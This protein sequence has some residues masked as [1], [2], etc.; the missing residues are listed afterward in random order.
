MTLFVDPENPTKFVQKVSGAAPIFELVDQD[1]SVVE[2]PAEAPA[3]DEPGQ[4]LTG[5][6]QPGAIR[7]VEGSPGPAGAN[8]SDFGKSE[9]ELDRHPK[10]VIVSG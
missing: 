10:S 2:L 7:P 8:L 4:D 5:V 1:G 9:I 3:A 6:T